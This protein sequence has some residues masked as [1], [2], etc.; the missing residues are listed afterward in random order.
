MKLENNWR[1]KTLENLEKRNIDKQ[2]YGSHLV[3]RCFELYKI[4]LDEFTIED[5]RIM[6]G[7]QIGLDYLIPLAID[8]LKLD[9]FAEGDYLEG[10]LLKSVLSVDTDFWNNNKEYWQTLNELIKDRRD[11]IKKA[12]FETIKF[13]NSKNKNG[14]S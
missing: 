3:K 11:E 2:T 13:D 8:A 6:I 1:Y 12:K 14:S 5:V 9:L 4:P 10:D 7:Q